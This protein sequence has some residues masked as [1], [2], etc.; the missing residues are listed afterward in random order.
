MKIIKGPVGSGKTKELIAVAAESGNSV[1][2]TGRVESII[3]KIHR[4]GYTNI[5]VV[6]YEEF[7]HEAKK[8]LNY[9]IDKMDDFIEYLS[10]NVGE[11]AGYTIVA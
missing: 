9:F 11:I 6:S 3:E 4:Y 1:I 2:V 8:D 10:A 7:L 5:Q